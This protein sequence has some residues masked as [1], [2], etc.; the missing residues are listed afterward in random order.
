MKMEKSKE[1]HILPH[2]ALI[3]GALA[4]I[5]VD[6]TLFPLDTVKTRCQSE[7]GFL[8]S[9]GF[10]RLFSGIGPVAAG[11]APGAA[12]FFLAY[13]TGKSTIFPKIVE[14]SV[15]VHALSASLAEGTSCLIRVPVEIIKQRM[16]VSAK[17]S[18]TSIGRVSIRGVKSLWVDRRFIPA[19]QGSYWVICAILLFLNTFH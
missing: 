16:Q 6:L 2:V 9:G 7:I 18:T 13:E 11:S 4:G 1:N 19:D 5:C 17:G 8:K 12:V 3:S 14:N 10:A 15:L